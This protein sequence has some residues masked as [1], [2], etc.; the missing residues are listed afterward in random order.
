[1]SY[2]AKCGQQLP[3]E[4]MNFISENKKYKFSDGE[5]CYACAKIKVAESRR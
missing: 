5:Y 4:F 3:G 1:M 2:C